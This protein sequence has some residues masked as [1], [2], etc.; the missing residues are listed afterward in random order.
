MPKATH[1]GISKGGMTLAQSSNSF[2]LGN[3]VTQ[4]AKGER[5]ST[6]APGTSGISITLGPV[7]EANCLAM[8]QPIKPETLDM[9]PSN[10]C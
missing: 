2:P 5:F 10:L 6:C 3:S 1:F 7:R 8:A 4:C 9:A